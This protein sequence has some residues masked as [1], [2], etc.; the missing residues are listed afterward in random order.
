MCPLTSA[1]SPPSQSDEWLGAYM[2]THLAAYIFL[3]R[4][5]L[6]PEFRLPSPAFFVPFTSTSPIFAPA[7][8]PDLQISS[9]MKWVGAAAINASPIIL[10][11]LWRRYYSRIVA[12]LGLHV[13]LRL[14]NIDRIIEPPVTP[15]SFPDPTGLFRVP[16]PTSGAPTT[17]DA[18]AS[19]EASTPEEGAQQPDQHPATNTVSRRPSTFSGRGDDYGS[20][21]EDNGAI[22][23]TLIS[24]DVEATETTDA[25]PPQAAQGV[26]SAELRPTTGTDVR[27]PDGQQAV[28]LRNSLTK[29]PLVHAAKILSRLPTCLLLCPFEAIAYRSLA[30]SYV[31]HRGLSTGD[32]WESNV[33]RAVTWGW[34]TNYLAVEFLHLA[35]QS[36]IWAGVTF[37][38]R[39]YH[40]TPEEWS[41]MTPE[42]HAKLVKEVD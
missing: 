34:V 12:N 24:F 1:N 13:F 38:G 18:P 16:D 19:Q 5:G 37:L 26:W 29:Q 3:Q 2:H 35:I 32:M 10:V 31:F 11:A 21:D 14:P 33:F 20:D 17:A 4:S 6:I 15:G 23:G 42:E 30:R 40:L 39:S 8:P 7:P 27:S 28:Y 41:D 9:I 22:S 25:A 36:D